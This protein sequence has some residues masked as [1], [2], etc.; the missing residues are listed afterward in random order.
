MMI[1]QNLQRFKRETQSKGNQ[2]PNRKKKPHELPVLSKTLL[3]FRPSL[4]GKY[5][6][7]APFMYHKLEQNY[8]QSLNQPTSKKKKGINANYAYLELSD[9]NPTCFKT[10]S[11]HQCMLQSALL[12]LHCQPSFSYVALELGIFTGW[13][14]HFWL[15]LKRS[16]E[17]Y[18]KSTKCRSTTREGRLF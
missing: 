13:N 17:I 6:G 18:I 3:R 15:S 11:S 9:K 2:S 14:K 10:Y 7:R 4:L 5:S 1:V 12:L 8:F 16:G